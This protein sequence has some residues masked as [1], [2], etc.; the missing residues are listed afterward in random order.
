MRP[1][2]VVDTSVFGGC[3]GVEFIGHACRLVA[4][5]A[6]GDYAMV[7]SALTLLELEKATAPS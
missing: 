2:I 6:G 1:R 7:I 3:E 5:M 4:A